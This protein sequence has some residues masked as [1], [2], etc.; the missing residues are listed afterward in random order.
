M[1]VDMTFE[2]RSCVVAI[3]DYTV[4]FCCESAGHDASLFGAIQYSKDIDIKYNEHDCFFKQP[5]I[6]FY[7]R[8]FTGNGSEPDHNKIKAIT[9]MSSHK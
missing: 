1:K 3:A 6:M 7:G 4:V 8:H 5:R 9:D 2:G